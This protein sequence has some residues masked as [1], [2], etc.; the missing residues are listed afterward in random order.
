MRIVVEQL[1][2]GS[3]ARPEE[4]VVLDVHRTPEGLVVH[5]D[6][7]YHGDPEP[8]CEP[9]PTDGLWNHEVVELFVVG[10][11]EE[12]RSYTEIELGPH[13]H[14]L[15]LRLKGVRCPVASGLPLAFRAERSGNRW[16]GTAQI[17]RNYLP[18]IAS[19]NAFAIHGVGSKRRY[20]SAFPVPGPH[21]DFHR[22]EAFAPWPGEGGE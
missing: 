11:K 4:R 1:W 20:L 7:P 9:G 22:L 3:P 6:A 18:E 12:P 14:H 16:V 21:P 5:V 10:P 17:P 2:D 15:V 8:P 13:G 19:Y